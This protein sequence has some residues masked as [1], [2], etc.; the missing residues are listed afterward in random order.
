M[1]YIVELRRILTKVLLRP[2]DLPA[3]L[4]HDVGDCDQRVGHRLPEAAGVD[5]A[6]FQLGDESVVVVR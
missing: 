2:D 5:E 6:P 1:I 3:V 4:D